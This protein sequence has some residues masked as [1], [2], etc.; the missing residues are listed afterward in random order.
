MWAVCTSARPKGPVG[1]RWDAG[2]PAPAEP[3]I[4]LRAAGLGSP[5]SRDSPRAGPRSRQLGG[6]AAAPPGPASRPGRAP[7]RGPLP[8]DAPGLAR[9]GS[10][11]LEAQ[12]GRQGREGGVLEQR[13]GL[14]AL[15]PQ[16]R[17][18]L[19]EVLDRPL[20]RA[21][22]LG[23]LPVLRQ[24]G[25]NARHGWPGARAAAGRASEGLG[26]GDERR[27]AGAR[28]GPGARQRDCELPP[29]AMIHRV[30]QR[31]PPCGR[32]LAAPGLLGAPPGTLAVRGLHSASRTAV[33]RGAGAAT[34]G[35]RPGW[36][37]GPA[38]S[39]PGIPV[40]KR[41]LKSSLTLA[42]F[43][44]AGEGWRKP[45]AGAILTLQETPCELEGER[46][47]GDEIS[48]VRRWFLCYRPHWTDGKTEQLRG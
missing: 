22:P 24:L 7:Y 18:V 8:L 43:P 3:R 28:P 27:S 2:D 15:V 44:L 37:S 6:R 39:T 48:S 30:P 20:V 46:A 34:C 36:P 16:R 38:A 11:L 26:C 19:V 25:R 45:K 4:G 10:Q 33:A 12:G 21:Q 29:P 1:G 23:R 17:V 47:G 5:R 13:P 35:R 41:G 9:V 40:E 42:G 14:Q 31:P 32:G